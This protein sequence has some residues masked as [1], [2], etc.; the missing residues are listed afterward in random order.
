MLF[1]I[2]FAESCLSA[3]SRV[4]R[5]DWRKSLDLSTN[6]IYIFFCFS[7][8][9]KFHSVI[10]QYKVRFFI[11]VSIVFLYAFNKYLLSLLIFKL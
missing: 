4:L 2:L 7:T 3:L 1:L 11:F 9:T 8:Y 6:I 5:E 10:V